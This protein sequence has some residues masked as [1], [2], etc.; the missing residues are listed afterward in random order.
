[1]VAA[2]NKLTTVLNA[3]SPLILPNQDDT[4]LSQKSSGTV[5]SPPSIGESGANIAYSYAPPGNIALL[6]RPGDSVLLTQQAQEEPAVLQTKEKFPPPINEAY[7]AKAATARKT[8]T[9]AHKPDSGQ[10]SSRQKFTTADFGRVSGAFS[11]T[12]RLLSAET[13]TSSVDVS[14]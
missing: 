7:F 14:I 10:D 11:R 1:M 5:L 9:P 4:A 12:D 3:T 2:L 8:E 13:A 6:S